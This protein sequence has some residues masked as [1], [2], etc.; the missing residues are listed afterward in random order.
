[1][2]KPRILLLGTVPP[3]DNPDYAL[4]S[5]DFEVVPFVPKSMTDFCQKLDTI[6]NDISAIWMFDFVENT[7]IS[8]GAE[9][10]SHFPETLKVWAIA[11]VGYDFVDGAAFRKKGVILTNTGSATSPQVADLALYHVLA[12]YRGTSVF[13]RSLRDQLNL[14]EARK[15]LGTKEFSPET[16]LPVIP[17]DHRVNYFDYGMA[18]GGK[19]LNTPQ[20][21]TV[22]IVGLG[23]IGKEIA[24]RLN[25]IG[26]YVNYTKRSPLSEEE[27]KK[28]GFTVTYHESFE[29]MI[30]YCDCIVFCVP[31]TPSTIHLL[32]EKTAKI[33]KPGVRIVNVGRGSAL[34]ENVLLQ[35]LEDGTIS[36][37]GLDVFESEPLVDERLVKR[38]DIT[39]TPHIGSTTSDNPKHAAKANMAD[40]SNI[41]LHGGKGYNTVN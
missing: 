29:K 35:C 38:W 40:I 16:G 4:F 1:M 14:S 17:V 12:S 2:T 8:Y 41:V 18:I 33:L 11:W 32:N 3:A 21:S 10:A 9:L 34:D 24:K 20:D 15:I 39:L 19:V 5:R 27:E 26:M 13:E 6:Y 23:A 36:H 7:D 28:L 25:A 31:H 22:G 30:P 37:A